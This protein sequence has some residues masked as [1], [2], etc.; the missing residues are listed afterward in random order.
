MKEF[1]ASKNKD[2]EKR[3]HEADSQIVKC[4]EEILVFS[5]KIFFYLISK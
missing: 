1:L 5:C 3:L 2:L 4:K